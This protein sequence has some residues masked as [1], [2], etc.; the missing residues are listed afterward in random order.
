MALAAAIQYNLDPAAN[1]YLCAW[2]H[3]DGGRDWLYDENWVDPDTGLRIGNLVW[4][5]QTPRP[6]CTLAI[7]LD[8][9]VAAARQFR[10]P[11]RRIVQGRDG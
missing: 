1:V 6:V 9:G 8:A 10:Y 11:T 5:T 2:V 7:M 3:V 4:S